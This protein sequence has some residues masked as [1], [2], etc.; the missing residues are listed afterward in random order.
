METQNTQWFYHSCM[1]KYWADTKS[2][3]IKL[4]RENGMVSKKRELTAAPSE[5]PGWVPPPSAQKGGT[6]LGS[7]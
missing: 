7:A 3:V 6:G 5:W 4:A 1:V 2:V